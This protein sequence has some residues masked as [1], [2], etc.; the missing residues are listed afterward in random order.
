MEFQDYFKAAIDR[1]ASDLHL[2]TG[3]RPCLR[4]D[5]ELI[6]ISEELID[7]RFLEESLVNVLEANMTTTSTVNHSHHSS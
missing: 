4:I 1:K 2:I 3:N 5:G 7:E 6:A